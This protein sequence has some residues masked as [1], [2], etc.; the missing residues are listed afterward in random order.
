[1]SDIPNA[2]VL[3][4]EAALVPVHL[5]LHL[6]VGS[7]VEGC[8]LTGALAVDDADA[9][10]LSSLDLTTR[11]T[12]WYRPSNPDETRPRNHRALILLRRHLPAV[13]EALH[14]IHGTAL[15]AGPVDPVTKR[16]TPLS[17][18]QVNSVLATFRAVGP[19][20]LHRR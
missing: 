15:L 11:R 16:L 3:P 13:D 14:G 20:D 17:V 5:P 10:Q 18:D 19:A 6:P 8:G 1:M 4:V 7:D 12:L 9:P 2:L